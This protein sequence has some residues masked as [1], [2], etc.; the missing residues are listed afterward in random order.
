MAFREEDVTE[1]VV[2]KGRCGRNAVG[3]QWE[4]GVVPARKVDLRSM[5]WS[6]EAK[7]ILLLFCY[8]YVVCLCYGV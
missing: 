2:D 1:L 4:S 3:R 8:C 7:S 6:F 5:N